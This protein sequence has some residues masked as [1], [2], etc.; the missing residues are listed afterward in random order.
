MTDTT[1]KQLLDRE[2]M[3]GFIA[4]RLTPT[5]LLLRELV[6]YGVQLI[7]ICAQRGGSLADLVV[8]GHFFKHAVTMLDGVEIQLSRGAVFAAGV[9]ARS[10]LEAYIYL[11]WILETDTE[12]RGRQFYVWHLRQKRMWARRVIPGTAEHAHFSKHT[13][14]LSDM[15]D[16]AKRAALEAEARKQDAEISGILTNANNNAINAAFDGMKKR[17]FDVAWYRPSGPSS[18]GD[19]AKR[20]NLDAEYDFFYSEFSDISH[21][22]AFEKHI[23]FDGGAVVFEPIRSPERI[24]AVVNIVSTL[25]L[26]VYRLVIDKYV[27]EEMD[28]FN[29]NYITRWRNRFLS[30]PEVVVKDKG[31]GNPQQPLNATSEGRASLAFPC[32]LGEALARER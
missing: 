5:I 17:H 32:A 30:V 6:D 11:A 13:A 14:T 20:L 1:P 3:D 26:N 10:M 15:K 31:S 4:D 18:I 19:M 9:S 23:K 21:A 22:G 24:R 7:D 27:P 12:A 29:K 25:A 16:P 2:T 28:T 8:K